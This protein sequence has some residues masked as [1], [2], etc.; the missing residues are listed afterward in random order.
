M[1]F[2]QVIF[3]IGF[4]NGIQCYRGKVCNE[5]DECDQN[6]TCHFIHSL[7]AI[8][9]HDEDWRQILANPDHPANPIRQLPPNESNSLDTLNNILEPLYDDDAEEDIKEEQVVFAD[10]GQGQ[11]QIPTEGVT[12]ENDET[13]L[14]MDLVEANPDIYQGSF[15]TGENQTELVAN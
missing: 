5:T 6:E 14:T 1:L 12:L 7:I 4:L 9:I 11:G 3:A 8:C 13:A 15:F 10:D 2:F